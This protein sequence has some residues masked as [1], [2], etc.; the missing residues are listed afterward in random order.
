MRAGVRSVARREGLLGIF[1]SPRESVPISDPVL[2]S[3]NIA[4]LIQRGLIVKSRSSVSPGFLLNV[5]LSK[6]PDSDLSDFLPYDSSEILHR[7]VLSTAIQLSPARDIPLLHH[8]ERTTHY[9]QCDHFLAVGSQA[10]RITASVFATIIASL[11][12]RI[13]ACSISPDG[14]VGTY[15]LCF[16]LGI[17]KDLDVFALMRKG[18]DEPIF[19]GDERPQ[20]G[21]ALILNDVLTTGRSTLQVAER[22]LN[23]RLRILGALVVYDRMQG[24]RELLQHHGIPVLSLMSLRSLRSYCQ[25]LASRKTCDH[26]LKR[27]ARFFLELAQRLRTQ[28]VSCHEVPKAKPLL[29]LATNLSPRLQSDSKEFDLSSAERN[30]LLRRISEAVDQ[31]VEN[32]CDMLVFPELTAP[33][34]TRKLF[35]KKSRDHP[36][37]IVAGTEYNSRMENPAIIAINGNIIEQAKLLRSPYDSPDMVTGDTIYVFRETRVGN[38]AV[39]VC[40]DHAGY[41]FVENLMGKVDLVVVIARNRAIRTFVSM[42]EGDSYRIYSYVLVVNDSKCGPSYISSP[43]K[44]PEKLQWIRPESVGQ[45][46]YARPDLG[47]L[48]RRSTKRF[49]RSIPHPRNLREEG[50]L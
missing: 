19:I 17:D 27:K 3:K 48:R 35:I 21:P 2:R 20:S 14:L 29:A 8:P 46:A 5:A 7:E 6:G 30:R 12:V 4:G 1:S 44:G 31:A 9:F 16:H 36:I 10:R 18:R 50:S 25:E 13:L 34:E 23:C 32:G 28:P 47:E 49:V 37:I 38:F 41:K 45:L 39:L 22:L 26:H 11:P 33:R 15:P 40:A 43:A 42:A 24:G